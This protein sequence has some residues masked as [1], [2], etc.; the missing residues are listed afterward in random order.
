MAGIFLRLTNKRMFTII[1]NTEHNFETKGVNI[2]HIGGMSDIEDLDVKESDIRKL[3]FDT[4]KHTD[5]EIH[6]VK[7]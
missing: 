6:Y 4:Y 7:I 3:I 5:S 1:K 2:T